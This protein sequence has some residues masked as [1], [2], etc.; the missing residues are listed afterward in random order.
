M[1]ES[2]LEGRGVSSL[3]GGGPP[4][5]RREVAA[6]RLVFALQSS[7]GRSSWVAAC[8]ANVC[9]TELVVIRPGC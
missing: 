8:S 6:V 5:T 7:G 4:G 9:H 1:R 3:V 2:G